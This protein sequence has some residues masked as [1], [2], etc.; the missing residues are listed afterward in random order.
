METVKNIVASVNEGVA[1]M[2]QSAQEVLGTVHDKVTN[3]RRTSDT[4]AV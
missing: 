4:A 1:G 3:S 2:A